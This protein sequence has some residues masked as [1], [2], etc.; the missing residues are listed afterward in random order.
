MKAH[1]VDFETA[2]TQLMRL[3]ESSEK[4]TLEQIVDILEGRGM[5][6]FL[7]LFSFPFCLPITLPG[8]S[9][10]FGILLAFLGLRIAFGKRAWWPKWLL[11]KE[12]KSDSIYKVSEKILYVLRKIKKLTHPRYFALTQRQGM[13]FA[14][15]ILIFILS[16]LLALPI[17][18]PFTNMIAAFPILLMGIGLLEDDGLIIILAYLFAGLCFAFFLG[19]FFLGKSL[20][21]QL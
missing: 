18:I 13:I 9:T 20:L 12:V 14:H 4:L 15:G 11:K 5:A 21:N 2:L 3:S 6:A 16:L 19:V 17:P 1:K 8:L 10:P 7:I